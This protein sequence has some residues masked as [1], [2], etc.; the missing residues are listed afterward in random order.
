MK[1][2]QRC[3]K[4]D[5]IHIIHYIENDVIPIGF[6]SKAWVTKYICSEC[7]YIESWIASKEELANL[8]NY[9]GVGRPVTRLSE[10]LNDQE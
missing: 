3:P 7:G 8:T 9:Y 4:C 6:F 5:C 10:L 2:S 1:N